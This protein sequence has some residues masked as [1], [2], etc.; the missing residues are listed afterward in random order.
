MN[1]QIKIPS[2]PGQIC[3][4]INPLDDEESNDVYIVTEDPQPYEEDDTI[5]V[6]ALKDLQRKIRN[7]ESATQTRITKNEIT[8]VAE[9]LEDYIKSWNNS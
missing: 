9:N 8:V 1:L 2:Q 6:V 3:K 5:Y 4:I 7:P